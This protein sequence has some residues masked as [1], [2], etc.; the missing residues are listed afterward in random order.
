M[1]VSITKSGMQL[2]ALAVVMTPLMLLGC[3]RSS[4]M[5]ISTDEI[6]VS[7]SAAPVCGST[8]AQDVAVR[9]AAIETINRGYDK[10]LITG[11]EKANN[12]RVVGT[13]PVTAYTTGT[14][15][16]HGYGNTATAYGNS[17]T[18][19]Y[20][21]DP[22]IGGTHD[23]GLRVKMFKQ[24]DPLAAKAISARGFLGPEW[25]KHVQESTRTTC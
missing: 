3:A 12:V 2:R 5:P 6:Q 8:G 7:T 14:A 20:G 11:G 23:Q 25:Q 17:T 9:R 18:Q 10:F 21:G 22:I 19:Y 15:T 16:A 13:T 24:D 4:V 1:A